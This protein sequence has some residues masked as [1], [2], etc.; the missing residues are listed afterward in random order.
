MFVY[1]LA[2]YG[3]KHLKSYA[4]AAGVARGE[5]QLCSCGIWRMQGGIIIMAQF[6]N[7]ADANVAA[8]ADMIETMRRASFDRPHH[9]K[10]QG[11]GTPAEG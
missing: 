6:C 5:R 3:G 1:V 2:A 7:S 10:N 8:P 9:K 4:I 11:S